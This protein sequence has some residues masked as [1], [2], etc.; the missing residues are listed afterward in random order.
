L[1]DEDSHDL[2]PFPE[3]KLMDEWL[4]QEYSTLVGWRDCQ[5]EF[6]VLKFPGG[7]E[8]S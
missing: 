3:V 6:E 2:E 8:Y 4:Q 7:A 5:F 1:S